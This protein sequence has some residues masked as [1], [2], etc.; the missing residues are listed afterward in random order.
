MHRTRIKICGITSVA[1]AL[2]AAAAGADAIGLVFYDESPRNVDIA[3]AERICEALPAFVTPVGLFVNAH[4]ERVEQV[5]DE[6]PLQ[7]LQF[8]GDETPAQCDLFQ[9]PWIKAIR[10]RAGADTAS[11][12]AHFSGAR[13]LL[14]DSWA[15]DKRGG[16]GEQ[17]DW[18]L[19]P[20]DLRQPMILAGGLT[21]QNVESGVIALR[22]WA[23]DVSS[24]VEASPGVKD[25]HKM[26]AFIAAVR[27]ADFVEE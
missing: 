19:A 4:P 23:V 22:P 26:D 3:L 17:F 21:P 10:V 25:A 7:L 16:T 12:A 14:L 6:V 20:R 13:A 18:S 27:E 2:A 15:A 9:R 1:D 24:G 8:H 5:V 11:E